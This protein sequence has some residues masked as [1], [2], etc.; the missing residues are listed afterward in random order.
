MTRE[1]NKKMSEN[2]LGEIKEKLAKE[3]P[4]HLKKEIQWLIERVEKASPE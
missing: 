2:R 3:V 4:D 1:R